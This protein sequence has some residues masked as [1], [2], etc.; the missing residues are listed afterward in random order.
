M[1]SLTEIRSDPD[2]ARRLV[3]RLYQEPARSMCLAQLAD[4]IRAAHDVSPSS[5]SV[6]L[7]GS[8]IRL[9]VGWLEALVLRKNELGLTVDKKAASDDKWLEIATE[10]G[11]GL[12]WGGQPFPSMESAVGVEIPATLIET[13]L[14]EL[15][16]LH[17]SHV[18]RA[19]GAVKTRGH[20]HATHSPGVLE[21]LRHTGVSDLPDPD[22]GFGNSAANDPPQRFWKISPGLKA[23]YWDDFR[24][25]QIIAI[26]WDDKIDL[27]TLNADSRLGFGS[28]L[29]SHP[30]KNPHDT[31]QAT[32]Q[33][34][35]FFHEMHI[36]DLVCAYGGKHILGCGVIASEYDFEPLVDLAHRRQ[37]DWQSVQPLAT[38]ELPDLLANKLMQNITILELS[39][40]E[41]SE[42]I[43]Q[44]PGPAEPPPPP[45]PS[46]PNLWLEA[47]L[48]DFG[49]VGL[50]FSAEIASNYVLALQTKR[51]VILTGIS[52]TGKTLLA[53]AIARHFR[54]HVDIREATL[55]P[56][57]AHPITIQPD[58]L[59]YQ[60]VILPVALTSQLVLPPPGQ[61]L[62]DRQIR[63]L[64]P[65]G[66]QQ[67]TLYRTPDG[68][69]T[70]LRFR[71]EFR[72]WVLANF[73]VGDQFLIEPL[74]TGTESM[75]SFRITA[76]DKR[77]HLLNNY[78]VA[79]VRPDWS[80]N[81]GLLG[82]F[83]PLVNTYVVTPLLR[84]LLDAQ[85]EVERA[86]REG[87]EPAPF[88]VILDEMNLARVEHYLSDFLSALESGEPV[89]LHDH[90]G[91]EEGETEGS[92]PVPRSLH[93]PENVFFTGTVNVDET[94]YMFSPKVLDRAFTIELNR[95]DLEAFGSEQPE[96]DS[97]F[98]LTRFDGS[99]GTVRKPNR[100]DWV[101]FGELMNGALR[102]VVLDIHALLSEE[103]RH[104]GYRVAN[105]IA[106]FVVLANE[107][108][109][110]S[111]EALWTALDLA[112]LQKI[113]PKF[114]GTQQEL[115]E[116][117]ARLLT[118]VEPRPLPR[119]EAKL[120]SM[121][122]RL[123]RQGFTSFIE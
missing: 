102:Q 60:R 56:E 77:P 25:Q 17:V 36:G 105:E 67:L 69:D 42:I 82:Y 92:V 23:K 118:F 1:A 119:I 63:V 55:V 13:L 58:R 90:E 109:D 51:F 11:L 32:N 83:N 57:N 35:T 22:Y 66:E 54:Q 39:K 93:V 99:I 94:T 101:E 15:K 75:P 31:T 14:P 117:L 33:L 116:V 29:S 37:I 27:R 72:Q 100:A 104:F 110:G 95:V 115:E 5:W 61:D 73:S 3:E 41:F 111:D 81:R 53:L 106:R 98:T 21:Y 86:K 107:Q 19:A 18:V 74:D 121:Q 89:H 48:S 108:T 20:F 47:L 52:G 38:S 26:G 62:S 8:E 9:N 122:R 87:R 30:D 43:R 7:H 97:A 96:E 123:R 78:I 10:P 113:L 114:H 59:M 70:V 46:G 84:L 64:Y 103:D 49:A 45:S 2:E 85:A 16:P 12:K 44:R 28:V 68:K 79:A 24:Q 71:G 112:V 40:E 34:W 80:D 6:T 65:L 4:S 120:R 91:I 50:R 76:P 88:F